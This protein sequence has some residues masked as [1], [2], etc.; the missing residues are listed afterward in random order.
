M[1]LLLLTSVILLAKE[2]GEWPRRAFG[3]N[4]GERKWITRWGKGEKGKK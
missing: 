1:D 3:Q 4:V 2:G